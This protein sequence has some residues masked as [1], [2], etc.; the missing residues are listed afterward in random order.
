MNDNAK[1]IIGSL[2]LRFSLKNP[3]VLLIILILFVVII[4]VTSSFIIFGSSSQDGIKD[5]DKQQ[6]YTMCT[7]G[8]L[9]RNVYYSM[10]EDAGVFSGKAQTFISVSSKNSIDPVLLASIAFNETGRGSSKMVKER[11]NPGGLYNSSAGTFFSYSTL[12]EGLDAM[13]SNL[14]RNYIS[15]GLVSITQI[16]AKYAPV[17]ANDPNGLNL[18][19]VPNVTNFANEFGGL[20][21]NCTTANMGSGELAHPIPNGNITSP[22]GYRIHPI[23]G[24]HKL[25]KGV[26]FS[27]SIGTPIYSA[28]N[29]T[30]AVAVKSGYGGGYGHH[31]VLQHGDKYTLYAHMTDVNVDK[32]QTVNQ[33]QMVGTCG[34][35]GGSTGPHLHFEV[36][37]GLYSNH[38]DPMPYLEGKK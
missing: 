30:V 5:Q 25:H 15:Q 9:N 34:S 31:V 2:A 36:Q 24:E 35:T 16:G 19:W 37:M 14:Y 12:D 18:N 26:D 1:K 28:S 10:F 17:G 32:G 22:F 3:Y 38:V 6:F 7:E 8:E 11:N 23:T 29:G 27:C 21:M 4:V 33:G 20:T 13:A